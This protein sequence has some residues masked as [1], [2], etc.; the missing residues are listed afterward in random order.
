MNFFGPTSPLLTAS[1]R[2]FSRLL[3]PLPF[4]L[5]LL[6]CDKPSTATTVNQK[7]S[8][9]QSATNND[10]AADD[11]AQMDGSSI[12]SVDNVDA[13]SEDEGQSLIAAAKPD[14]SL[15]KRRSPMISEPQP[16]NALQATLIG[17]YAGILPCSFCDGVSVTLNLFADSSVLKTSVYENPQ[18]PRVPLVEHGIY[19]QDSN[20]ITVVYDNKD[21]ESYNIQSNHLVMLDDDKK[22]NTDYT[23][24]R[25]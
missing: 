17:D 5:L 6:G 15:P 13:D 23:L 18:T 20:T 4:C 12:D 21:I 8:V 2:R 19:R 1:L 7:A 11:T 9:Q 24:A 22:P 25:K 3:L 10:G 16:D 14:D